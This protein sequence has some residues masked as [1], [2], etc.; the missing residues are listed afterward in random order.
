MTTNETIA[1]LKQVIEME[2]QLMQLRV[3]KEELELHRLSYTKA[4]YYKMHKTYKKPS[5]LVEWLDKPFFLNT[6]TVNL[7]VST[8]SIRSLYPNLF[9][10]KGKKAGAPTGLKE[11]EKFFL[12]NYQKPKIDK[13]IIASLKQEPTPPAVVS[14][15]QKKHV[16]R[17]IVW[18]VGCLLVSPF[19]LITTHVPGTIGPLLLLTLS[20]LG[21]C[22]VIDRLN[23]VKN[24]EYEIYKQ[25]MDQYLKQKQDYDN[26]VEQRE[27][28]IKTVMACMEQAY[29]VAADKAD[30][31]YCAFAEQ[32]DQKLS[33]E[34]GKIILLI[35][36]SAQTLWK[37]YNQD[38]IHTKYRNLTSCCMFLEYL[39]SG[40]CDTLTG[41]NG[42]YNL[43]E[44]ELRQDL[45]IYKLDE[46]VQR[47]D[48]LQSTMYRCCQAIETVS[49]KLDVV[50]S[51]LQQL[52]TKAK[53]QLELSSLTAVYAAAT[54]ANT[55]A[56][57]YL[58]LIN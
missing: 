31:A 40:R 48:T 26:A 46:V 35:N 58:T 55:S 28:A 5:D 43:Y 53:K 41:A 36:E 44:S 54:A 25:Q 7:G 30:K 47:L 8:A 1:Y 20:M 12:D 52:D 10:V 11:Q 22:W 9:A 42:A 16:N 13:N 32:R 51:D 50:H 38:V 19:W 29:T 21:I 3:V 33:R 18:I 4:T 45:I 49:R 23:I 24:R 27:Q 2:Q 14:I 56:I 15:P 34:V 39:E 17:S 6:R 57:K 37:L